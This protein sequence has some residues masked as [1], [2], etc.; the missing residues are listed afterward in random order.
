MKSALR[1]AL[2][3]TA[4]AVL[5][6]VLSDRLVL[7]FAPNPEWMTTISICKGILYV[8]VTA[9]LLYLRLTKN[10]RI[11]VNLGLLLT[12]S[13]LV[14]TPLTAAAHRLCPSC[15]TRLRR[16]HIWLGWSALVLVILTIL[17]GLITAGVVHPP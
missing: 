16:V 14:A 2:I 3:Y 12:L 10:L 7:L 8:L 6:I 15:L 17:S 9:L 13:L 1:I 11:A 4:V 5:W